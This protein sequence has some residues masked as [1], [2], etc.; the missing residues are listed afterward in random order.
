VAATDG[1]Y[2][3]L[4]ETGVEVLYDDRNDRP[5]V[6][7][8]DADLIGNPIRLSVSKRTLEQDQA[9]LRL[10][11]ESESTFVP[12]A[13]VVTTVRDHIARL[14]TVFTSS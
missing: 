12:I 5:G 13:E 7:F 14:Q 10:R 6:K 9:E 11:S 2:A 4:T 3:A 8:N 1:L